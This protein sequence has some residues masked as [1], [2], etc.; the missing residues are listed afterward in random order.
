[1]EVPQQIDLSDVSK[2]NIHLLNL[3]M[4]GLAVV[5]VPTPVFVMRVELEENGDD[6][7]LMLT[8]QQMRTLHR[9]MSRSLAYVD[10]GSN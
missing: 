10:A 3:K 2:E 8:V 4:T 9:S 5:G 7:L 1:M 6:H